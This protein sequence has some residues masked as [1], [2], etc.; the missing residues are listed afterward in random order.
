MALYTLSFVSIHRFAALFLA[1]TLM[2]ATAQQVAAAELSGT[3]LET[4]DASGYTYMNL[5]TG[6][7][8]VWVAIPQS[9]INKGQKV[10][11]LEGMEMKDFHSNSFD[12]TFNSII[13]SPGLVGGASMSPHGRPAPPAPSTEDS[14]AAAVEAERQASSGGAAPI[15]PQQGSAGSMGAVAPFTETEVEKAEGENSFTVAEIFEQ[16]KDL[17]GKKVRVRGQVVKFNANIMGRNWLH[18][19]D[20]SGDPMQNTHDLVVTTVEELSGPNVIT[21]EGVVAA[22]KDFGAGYKYVVLIEN[23][24]IVKQ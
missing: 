20:G 12:R 23:S 18:L 2:L 6:D 24:T 15:E 16:A 7:Q 19:Q 21:I 17:N 10:S 13:F 14:F 5:D 3:V 22:D 11:V 9:E 8:Q 1:L 4:M